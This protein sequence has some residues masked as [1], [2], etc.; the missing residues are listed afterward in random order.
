MEIISIYIQL[1][2]EIKSIININKVSSWSNKRTDLTKITHILLET[3]ASI[4]YKIPLVISI[5]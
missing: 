1:N 5:R 3:K 2:K 4:P